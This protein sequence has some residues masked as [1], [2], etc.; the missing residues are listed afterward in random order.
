MNE[1]LKRRVAALQAALRRMT[2]DD[3][4]RA[5]RKQGRIEHRNMYAMFENE[6][7]AG[8][9]GVVRRL[10]SISLAWVA[11]KLMLTG[12]PRRGH[13][14]QGIARSIKSRRAFIVQDGGFDIDITAPNI[15]TRVPGAL[16]KK[17]RGKR[18]H[19]RVLVNAYLSYYA[20]AKAPGL[21]SLSTQQL[22][23]ID[24]ARRAAERKRLRMLD[25][26]TVNPER[27]GRQRLVSVKMLFERLKA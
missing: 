26:V 7:Y 14:T 15:T 8:V 18:K 13:F 22:A 20:R 6:R 21:G 17:R 19:K 1:S 3:A 5:I 9:D 24:A 4:I 11:R 12:E 27:G 16:K 23:R 10:G 25:G 2:A